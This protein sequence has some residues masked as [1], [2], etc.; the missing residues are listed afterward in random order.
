MGVAGFPVRNT[1]N[2]ENR[3]DAQDRYFSGNPKIKSKMKQQSQC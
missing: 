1:S 3:Q 2:L